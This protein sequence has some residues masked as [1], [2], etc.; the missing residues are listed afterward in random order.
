VLDSYQKEQLWGPR[1]RQ[2]TQ[3]LLQQGELKTDVD[4]AMANAN[5][6]EEDGNE[7]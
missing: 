5:P 2:T 7:E 3:Q 4:R 6:E 1:L